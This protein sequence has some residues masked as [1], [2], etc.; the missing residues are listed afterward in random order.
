MQDSKNICRQFLGGIHLQRNS[1]EAQI[2][3]PGASRGMFAEDGIRVRSSH[4]NA[5]CFT[6]D[7]KDG[8]RGANSSTRHAGSAG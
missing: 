3:N 2:Q 7:R 1:T 4:R 6:N 5:F 8:F